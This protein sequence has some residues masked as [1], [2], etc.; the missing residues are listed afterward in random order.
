MR[1][2]RRSRFVGA[3]LIPGLIVAAG[4]LSG[5]CSH[6]EAAPMTAAAYA[7]NAKKAYNE[8]LEAYLD[9]DWELAHDLMEAVTRNYGYSRY[10]RLAQLRLA[11]IQFHQEAFLEA[12]G[13]YKSFV[14]D[15]PNDPE[16]R[17]ARY[18]I[19]QGEFSQSSAGLLL[20]PLEE[21]DLS[22]VRDAYVSLKSFLVDF[23]GDEHTVE[24][25]YMLQVVGGLLARHELYVAHYYLREDEFDATIARCKYALENFPSSGLEPEALV[26]LGETYLRM[27]D[28]KQ[29]R[30]SFEQVLAQYSDSAFVIPARNFLQLMA[31]TESAG[32]KARVN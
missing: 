12:V 6:H 1:S 24:L 10:A 17:Y 11:D 25:T 29:A 7:A 3:V 2:A 30:A 9:R 20:P 22:N 19:A 5:G 31:T 14:R 21:R 16:V 4:A 27:K 28:R 18:R 13:D 26:L 32:A 23:P 15:F 8:A